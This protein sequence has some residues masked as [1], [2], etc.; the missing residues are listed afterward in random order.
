MLP[1]ETMIQY[2][3]IL[4]YL[5]YIYFQHIYQS[6]HGCVENKYIQD[7]LKS[8]YYHLYGGGAILEG[9]AACS[10]GTDK[11]EVQPAIDLMDF[12]WHMDVASLEAT[13]E[14]STTTGT[15][16]H[17]SSENFGS[18]AW[19]FLYSVAWAAAPTSNKVIGFSGC[20]R[21]SWEVRCQLDG[22]CCGLYVSCCQ[23][24]PYPHCA[25]DSRSPPGCP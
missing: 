14:V 21:T 25:P 12:G 2:I 9:I 22:S 24:P 18:L 13:A 10:I 4:K 1:T 15:H 5:V 19:C 6:Y 16:T 8:L 23:P 7:I 20:T 17:P 3:K 11:I